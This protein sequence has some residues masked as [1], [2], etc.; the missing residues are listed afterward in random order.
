M[1][2]ALVR[3]CQLEELLPIAQI[4][5]LIN[6]D[7]VP[8]ATTPRKV[9]SPPPAGASVPEKKK[10]ADASGP[11]SEGLAPVPLNEST[12]SAVLQQLI[13]KSGFAL[14]SDLRKANSTA[15]SGPNTLV[16]SVSRRYNTGGNT[17]TDPAQ[18]AKL[19]EILSGIVGEPCRVK[20]DWVDDNGAAPTI[21]SA[22]AQAMGQQ[23]LQR[24]ELL[25]IPLVK[26]VSEV[27]GAQIIR[28]D[29]GF[30]SPAKPAAVSEDAPEGE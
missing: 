27:L 23:R 7:G 6:R 3:L 5:Q 8:A 4:A 13:A 9:V 1:E 24:A 14:Q 21:K 12:L 11:S 2:M 10:V 15:I 20:V 30:G 28:A 29:E 19:E 22:A 25:Q 18:S 26:K 17:F 16:F